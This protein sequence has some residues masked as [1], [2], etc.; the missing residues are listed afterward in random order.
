MDYLAEKKQEKLTHLQREE[1]IATALRM[2]K[3][4]NYTVHEIME[5]SKLTQNEIQGLFDT[6]QNKK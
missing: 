4:G 3:K 2:I 5:A 1:R 6:I